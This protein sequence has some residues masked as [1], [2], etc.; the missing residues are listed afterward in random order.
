[1]NRRTFFSDLGFKSMGLA[2]CFSMLN[3]ARCGFHY[4]RKSKNWVWITPDTKASDD[5]WK[6][7][8]EKLKNAGF[9]AILPE[10]YAGRGAYFGSSRMPVRAE[11]LERLIPIARDFDLELHAWMWTMPCLL[12]DI[13]KNH[14][15][16]YN[17]NRLGQS[18]V[19]KPAYVGYYKFLCPTKE[20]VHEFIQGTV[21]ELSQYDVDGVHLDYVRYPDVI[22]AKG[23]WAKYDLIQDK[24]Y[25]QF[26]YCYCET[27]R[28][29]F[30]DQTGI[31]PM[32][33][34]DPSVHSEWIQFRHD[35]VTNLVNNKLIPIGH[36]HGKMMTA[37]VFPNWKSVRQQWHAWKLDAA[38]PMLYNRFYE[39]DADWIKRQCEEGIRSLQF[40]TKL[41]SGLMLDEPDKFR[42]YV[43]KSF[44]GGANGISVFSFRSLKDEHLYLLTELLK[45]Y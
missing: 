8:F 40:D 23:L 39:E 45:N 2:G 35:Q 1:M 16:W 30:K 29:K 9:D 14:P 7:R 21:R 28:K 33:I 36:E 27:C 34:Q 31:D 22:L 17:V 37:A 10:I 18:S 24:E 25:P 26:D 6:I 41:Y 13:Q 42:E 11:L 44:E 3:T 19:D 20:E 15:D 5:D 32:D 43:I 12:D 38:L 4:R